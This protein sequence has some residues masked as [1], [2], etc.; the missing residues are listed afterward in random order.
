MTSIKLE[1]N[2]DNFL[3]NL[4]NIFINKECVLAELV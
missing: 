1:I 2:A 4:E 3:K